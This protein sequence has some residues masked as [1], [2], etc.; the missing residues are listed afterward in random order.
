MRVRFADMRAVTRSMTVD[1]PISATTMLAEIAEELVR[2]AL[3]DHPRERVITLLAISISHLRK[4]AELQWNLPGWDCLTR[5]VGRARAKAPRVGRP[6]AQ[7]TP[8]GNASAVTLSATRLWRWFGDDRFQTP[9]ENWP[10]R[11]WASTKADTKAPVR[12]GG[13][14]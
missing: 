12:L 2:K 10:K 11:T 3:A 14:A 5:N 13:G 6:I 7:L 8:F 1:A 9:F 4:Q